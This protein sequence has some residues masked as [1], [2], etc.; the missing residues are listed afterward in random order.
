MVTD[1]PAAASALEVF[2]AVAAV[3]VDLQ[4]AVAPAADQ[5]AQQAAQ[6]MIKELEAVVPAVHH[7][8]AV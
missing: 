7:I 3:A 4:V 1:K 5:Q 2:L 8:Q 6:V